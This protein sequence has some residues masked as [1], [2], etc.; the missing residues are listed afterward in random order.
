MVDTDRE[1]LRSQSE[2][3]QDELN[4]LIGWHVMGDVLWSPGIKAAW[5]L[6]ESCDFC[7]VSL[8]L[9]LTFFG[10]DSLF[11]NEFRSED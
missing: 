1:L 4:F 11:H 5:P 2:S 9:S 8:F 7:E 6:V 10:V 3:G